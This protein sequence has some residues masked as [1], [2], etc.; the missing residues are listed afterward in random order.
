MSFTSFL[1]FDG[2]IVTSFSY[3]DMDTIGLRHG[4]LYRHRYDHADGRASATC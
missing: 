3:E 1:T 2:N 4:T